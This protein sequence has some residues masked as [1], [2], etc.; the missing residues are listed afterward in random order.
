[1][2]LSANRVSTTPKETRNFRPIDRLRNQPI[3][4]RFMR[5]PYHSVPSPASYLMMTFSP[6]FQYHCIEKFG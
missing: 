5:L 4:D 6:L 2:R 1:V 3:G